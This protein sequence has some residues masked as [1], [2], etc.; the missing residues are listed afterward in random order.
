MAQ[1]T[2]LLTR[3][4]YGISDF[5]FIKGL[6]SDLYRERKVKGLRCPCFG[7]PTSLKLQL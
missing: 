2:T 4:G 3:A 5:G 7:H 6:F 1:V